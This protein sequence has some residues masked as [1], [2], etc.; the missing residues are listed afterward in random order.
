[1]IYAICRVLARTLYTLVYRLEARG[2]S[3]VP[4]SGPVV[5]CCNHISLQDPITLATWLNRKVYYMAKEELFRIPILRTI[6]RYFGAFPVKRGGVSKEAVRTAIT[7]LREGKMLGIFPEGTRNRTL[8]EGKR[9]AVT[10]AMRAGAKVVPVALIGNYRPFTK[11]IVVYG[12]PLD[13]TPYN[14]DTEAATEAIMSCIRE[15]LE[16][17]RPSSGSPRALVK[18]A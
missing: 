1:M 8:G 9:G 2:V 10:M 15:M 14:G 11:M 7:F 6:I 4:A 3:N 13:L 12:E 18:E 16:T 17:G 5:L